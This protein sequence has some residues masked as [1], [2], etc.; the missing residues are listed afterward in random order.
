MLYNFID[1]LPKMLF[2]FL[3]H[4]KCFTY[5]VYNF[6]IEKNNK[7]TGYHKRSPF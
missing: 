5:A 7:A 1:L 6:H 2:D 3:V 4:F